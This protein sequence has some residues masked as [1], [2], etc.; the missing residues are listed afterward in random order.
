METSTR[1]KVLTAQL[2]KK[3]V[4]RLVAQFRWGVGTPETLHNY[5]LYDR[6]NPGSSFQNGMT[7]AKKVIGRI[8]R[9]P[10]ALRLADNTK[11]A[12]VQ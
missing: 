5:E 10:L 7:L 11:S 8:R 2:A 4:Q 9:V 1:L 3:I 6:I 12:E